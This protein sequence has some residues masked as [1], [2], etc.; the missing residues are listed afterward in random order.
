MNSTRHP[1]TPSP[2]PSVPSLGGS[3][4]YC[5]RLAR[6]AASSFYPAFCL[7]PSGQRRAMC[8]LYAFLRLTDDLADGPGALPE[9]TEA[10][11]DWRQATERCLLGRY[12]H[13]LHPAFDQTVKRFR[14]PLE[15][16]RAAIDGVEMDLRQ[17]RYATFAELYQ[18]CYRVASVVGLCCIHIWGFRDE[19]AKEYAER[20][21]IAFQ[22]T[23]VLRD[24]GEDATRGRVYLPLEDLNRFGM[25]PE[26]LGNVR[27][28]ANGLRPPGFTE[29]MQVEVKRARHYYHAA[30]PLLPLLPRPGRAVFLTMARTYHGLLDE[31]ERRNYDVYS[32]RVRVGFWRKLAYFAEAM[33]LRWGWRNQ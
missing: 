19:R 1:V 21:G 2:R 4:T 9:K 13:P 18:Y 7:L 25:S 8:A 32:S 30:W 17:T 33:P 24:L 23:N 26:D 20:A 11:A 27:A 31:I 12:A 14:I 16:V 6:Q 10:L 29:M 5:E 28:L 15:Y 3:Y 22:L